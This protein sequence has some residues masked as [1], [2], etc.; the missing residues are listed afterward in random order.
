[1]QPL[2]ILRANIHFHVIAC[3]KEKTHCCCLYSCN[4]VDCA[5]YYQTFVNCYWWKEEEAGCL[6]AA[7]VR[8]SLRHV[9]FAWVPP[10]GREV[11]VSLSVVPVL[12]NYTEVMF[13]VKGCP[14]ALTGGIPL[15]LQ[16]TLGG[17]F[18]KPQLKKHIAHMTDWCLTGV[19]Q[20]WICKA[21]S[22]S[23]MDLVIRRI[24]QSK[25]T[26]STLINQSFFRNMTLLWLHN[27]IGLLHW[28]QSTTLLRYL[29]NHDSLWRLLPFAPSCVIHSTPS[30]SYPECVLRRSVSYS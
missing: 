18:W 22:E 4:W 20:R 28:R 30:A 6:D 8:A 24:Q 25:V 13:T 1:M 9:E 16:F 17:I 3:K 12:T 29:C 2:E 7:C 5:I 27:H 21:H 23:F 10:I 26:P 15:H 19:C 11:H 14:P